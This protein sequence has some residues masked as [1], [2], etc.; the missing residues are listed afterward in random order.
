MTVIN[1]T[2][3]WHF[4]VSEELLPVSSIQETSVILVSASVLFEEKE[5]IVVM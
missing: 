3:L 5:N 4:W 1:S 2:S